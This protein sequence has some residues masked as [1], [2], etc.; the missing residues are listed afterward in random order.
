MNEPINFLNKIDTT[1][2]GTVISCYNTEGK[3]FWIRYYALGQSVAGEFPDLHTHLH[4]ELL[5]H[6]NGSVLYN[7]DGNEFSPSEG[8]V[9]VARAGEAHNPV[10]I[11]DE[12]YEYLQIDFPYDAFSVS[13]I[14]DCIMGLFK[15]KQVCDGNFLVPDPENRDKILKSTRKIIA[16]LSNNSLNKMLIYSYVI[17]LMDAVNTTFHNQAVLGSSERTESVADSA[18]DYI[19]SHLVD[20]DSVKEVADFINMSTS[21]LTRIFKKHF[22]C[23]PYEFIV[24]KRIENAKLLMCYNGESVSEACRKSGFKNYSNFI[25]LFKKRTGMTPLVY[26]K[27]N[28]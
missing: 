18:V 10:V 28:Q 14:S 6:L 21:Q 19:Y 2:N 15:N 23:T 5:V 1:A 12:M 20:I 24:D 9:I 4:G 13:E 22:G 8:D 3:C 27:K 7:V 17:Q 25:A 11:N 16:A 26:K